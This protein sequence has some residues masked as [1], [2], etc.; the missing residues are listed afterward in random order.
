MTIAGGTRA[1]IIAGALVCVLAAPT[2]AFASGGGL[3]TDLI[4]WGLFVPY[5]LYGMSAMAPFV[6]ASAF[7]TVRLARRIFWAQ[8]YAVLTAGSIAIGALYDY[9]GIYGLIYVPGQAAVLVVSLIGAP[10]PARMLLTSLIPVLAVVPAFVAA[11][12]MWFL[13]R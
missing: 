7:S 9:V 3:P 10:R 12:F 5:L 1:R 2:R 13:N 4:V 11:G 8:A 6:L